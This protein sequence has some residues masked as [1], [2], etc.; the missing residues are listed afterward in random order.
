MHP[1]DR[2]MIPQAYLNSTPDGVVIQPI[3]ISP[4]LFEI[5]TVYV[6]LQGNKPT[7]SVKTPIN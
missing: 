6:T 1:N 4:I 7:L 3:T 2:T 5:F